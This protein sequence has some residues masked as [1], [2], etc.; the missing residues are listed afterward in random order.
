M[1]TSSYPMEYSVLGRT[2]LKVS[3]LGFGAT[4]I[5]DMYS[6]GTQRD[7]DEAVAAALD[8][9]I[10]YFDASP[11][12]GPEG[13]A[14]ERLG[15][16][17]QGRRH[18]VVLATKC[19]R[20]DHGQVNAADFE[21]DYSPA[22][23]RLEIE[24]SL[25]RL[26][27]DY[28]DLYQIHEVRMAP[29]LTMLI[30]ETL[31][32]MEKL[33]QEGKVRYLGV[34]DT[35]LDMLRYVAERSPFVDMVLTFSRYNLV[36]TSLPGQ[37]DDLRRQRNLG[38]VNSS[39]MYIGMLTMNINTLGHH[40]AEDKHVALKSAVRQCIAL[41]REHGVDLGEMAMTFGAHCDY[42]DSTLVA[43]GKRKRV[44]QN[45]RLFNTPVDEAFC[46][47]LR[48]ILDGQTMFPPIPMKILA[49]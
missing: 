9:G 14:E 32:E 24:N 28:L 19:G 29:S 49:R 25:R 13:L 12:Y 26:K 17:L 40:K 44:E 11:S 18:Q 2:G 21:F 10:N 31:P 3:R 48:A 6:N 38:V 15:T 35:Y 39:V 30:E 22:R 7:A 5:G 27:T 41:C 36:D 23:V 46:A 47:R 37:F 42:A 8:A 16:A 43:M 45:L 34:T 1:D 4:G 33:R 20:Y